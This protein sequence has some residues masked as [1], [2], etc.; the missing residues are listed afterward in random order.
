M[1]SESSVS[2]LVKKAEREYAH[3]LSIVGLIKEETGVEVEIPMLEAEG[4]AT[5]NVEETKTNNAA[6]AE[7]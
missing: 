6:A 5:H 1:S 3:M 2:F 7:A 4:A